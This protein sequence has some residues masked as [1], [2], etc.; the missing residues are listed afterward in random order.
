M[1]PFKIII[2]I[3]HKILV[4][5]NVFNWNKPKSKGV[6]IYVNTCWIY[7]EYIG[8]GWRIKQLKLRISLENVLQKHAKPQNST[9]KP[10]F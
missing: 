7:V 2:I 10:Q 5:Q 3:K 9:N 8:S 1:L 6:T 4:W